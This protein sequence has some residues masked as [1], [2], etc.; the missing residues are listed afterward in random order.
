MANKRK[1]TDMQ[2]LDAVLPSSGVDLI[3]N[4]IQ[5]DR[6]RAGRGEF[7]EEREREQEQTDVDYDNMTSPMTSPIASQSADVQADMPAD[8]LPDVHA[9]P[10]DGPTT[11][12]LVSL[13]DDIQARTSESP[14]DDFP[15]KNQTDTQEAAT[16]AENDAN[17][18]GDPPRARDNQPIA[19]TTTA[20]RSSRQGTSRNRE[21]TNTHASRPSA[22]TRERQRAAVER[23]LADSPAALLDQLLDQRIKR[24]KEMSNS[25]TMT[26][27]LRLPQ[28]M[29]DW[30]DEYV[31]EN[32]RDRVKKQQL[33]VE[34]LQML[35]ARRGQAGE[36]V[37]PT[38]LLGEGSEKD[39]L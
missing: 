10:S 2:G 4:V 12:P 37:L 32:W 16:Q 24:A 17:I 27:T 11:D 20:E 21:A 38:E 25:R 26:V 5:S 3:A 6:R 23:S 8:V 31:H 36:E 1:P 34:A 14:L 19:A 18:A 29:N 22:T 35:I 9:S 15:D 33:V 39:V 30:L 13:S 28:E 7:K